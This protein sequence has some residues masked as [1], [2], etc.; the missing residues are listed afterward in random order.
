[1][2]ERER[3]IVRGGRAQP[4]V[5]KY[6]MV[7][8]IARVLAGRLNGRSV[9]EFLDREGSIFDPS[10]L[11]DMDRFGEILQNALL[12]KKKICIVG[13]YDV[14]GM[15]SSAILYLG[16]KRLFPS[17]DLMIRIPERL[18]DGYGFSFNIAEELLEEKVDLALTCDNGVREF[19]SIHYL[20][21]HGMR[22]VVT[23]HHEIAKTE[24]GE[25]LLPE[26]DA[27]VNPHRKGDQSPEKAICGAF[28]AYQ[29]MRFLAVKNGVSPEEDA[30]FRRMK[31]YAALGTICDV[32]PLT[33]NN[34]RLVY[35]GLKILNE[36]TPCGIRAMMRAASIKEISTYAAGFVIGPMINAGGRLGSQNRFLEILLSDSEALCRNL[37]Q[38]LFLLNKHRQQMTEDGI[39]E[40]KAQAE[41]FKE[42]RV[43]VIYLPD[44]HES[45]AG[46]VAGK[47]R[48]TLN[49][50]TFVMTK[51]AEGVK[52]SGRSI[53]A[54]SMF[55]EMNRCS[56]LFEKFGGHTMAAG[57]T[58]KTENG[59]E[60][61]AVENMRRSMNEA[62][63]LRDEDMLPIVYIDAVMDP[64]LLSVNL[65]KE[66]DML[67]PFGNGNTKP[68]LAMKH[69]ELLSVRSIGKT[70]RFFS[71]NFRSQA[72][73]VR[74]VCFNGDMV[75]MNLID[76]VGEKA[77]EAFMAGNRINETLFV[78]L[79]YYADLD[80]YNGEE[81][82]S[83]KV[84]HL[85]PSAV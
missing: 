76:M 34:R 18:T 41:K 10:L 21:E 43:K 22:V 85:R 15:T 70:G 13:D 27:V 75:R 42:D 64:S 17:A 23:D 55:D 62:C 2:G 84:Q 35:Q 63:R 82:V 49:C 24:E 46:L 73:Y 45:I 31:G 56:G 14:D 81:R 11:L 58:L 19:E 54:Y 83:L 60:E 74:G 32:M 20:K 72:G 50:P 66:L 28:V 47:L 71:L 38:E 30:V 1:M 61:E 67:G 57:F 77:A 53:E 40:G 7:P 44:L 51:G 59:H 80:E 3:W 8:F 5:E 25:D 16:I 39:K 79:V 12:D 69:L 68:H 65:V 26:A 37:A 52:G 4:L 48:E 78:D 29:C 9:E 33:G 6:Q 36:E